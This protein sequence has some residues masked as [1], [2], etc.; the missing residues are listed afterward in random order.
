MEA[1]ADSAVEANCATAAIHRSA[2]WIDPVVE[3]LWPSSIADYSVSTLW[4][5]DE[6]EIAAAMTGDRLRDN[7]LLNKWEFAQGRSILESFPWRLS[8]PFVQCNAQCDFCAA[9]LMQGKSTLIDLIEAL[10]PAI[11]HCY[12][13]DLVGWGEPLIHPEFP[14]ILDILK[15]ESDPRA[16]LALTTNGTRLEQWAD[17]LLEANILQYA[18][19]IHAACEPTHCNLMGFRVGTFDR[20]LDGV[21]ALVNRK[22]EHPGLD[23]ETVLVVTR[24]NIQEIPAF[25]DLSV[26]LGVDRVHLRTLMPQAEPREGLDYHRLPPYLHSDFEHLRLAAQGAISASPIPVR[27]D[28]LTWSVPVFSPEWEPKLQSLPVTAR[29]TRNAFPFVEHDWEVLGGGEFSQDLA[30]CET[31][32]DPF[33]RTAPLRCP[34]P[35]TAFYVNGTDRRVIPCVYMHKVPDH[36]F[37]HF[38][39]SMSFHD[40][41]NAPALVAVRRHLNS[42]PLMPACLKCPFYC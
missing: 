17:R 11:R 15:R 26:A 4:H 31:L 24:Q 12:Q 1:L 42:G 14:Q 20:V 27:G 33:A 29:R 21:R 3:A 5:W 16:R 41:W 19:S 8:I 36:E 32:E 39:P 38:K 2:P 28:P 35:Y 25:I 7:A 37:M 6:G 9:W 23:V 13:L 30:G 18:V 40:I 10:G 34:S 22:T